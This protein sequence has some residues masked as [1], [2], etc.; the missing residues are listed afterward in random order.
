MATALSKLMDYFRGRETPMEEKKEKKMS[1]AAYARG[2][3]ME[4]ARP[5]RKTAPAKK[6]APARK[7]AAPAKKT[8]KK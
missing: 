1:P 3:K 7:T 8:V 6:A 2:E 4:A 5:A